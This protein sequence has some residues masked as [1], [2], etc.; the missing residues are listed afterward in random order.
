MK[1]MRSIGETTQAVLTPGGCGTDAPSFEY[2]ARAPGTCSEESHGPLKLP[3]PDPENG[4]LVRRLNPA[5]GCQRRSVE[6]SKPWAAGARG[7][8]GG[9]YS[10]SASVEICMSCLSPPPRDIAPR[11]D[12]S[13]LVPPG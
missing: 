6:S 2:L 10:A 8:C 12:L 11:R 5:A 7:S 9:R 13:A 4:L 1:T 3:D